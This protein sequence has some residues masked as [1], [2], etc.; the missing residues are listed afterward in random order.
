MD[1]GGG[2]A[3]GGG[4]TVQGTIGQPDAG[5]MSGGDFT[6]AAG[7]WQQAASGGCGDCP[8]DLGP[9]GANGAVGPE[10]LGF[11]LGCWGELPGPVPECD[12]VNIGPCPKGDPCETQIGPE[13]LGRLLGDWGPC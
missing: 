9:P 10:D 12:C 6:L 7:F 11:L 3:T 8:H 1:G 4:F 2:T 13:D 5:L